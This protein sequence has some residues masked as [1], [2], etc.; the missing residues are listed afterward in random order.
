M[1]AHI[2]KGLFWELN[3]YDRSICLYTLKDEDHEGLPSL[4]R[5]YMEME[6]PTEWRFANEYLDGWSH[7]EKIV[8]SPWFK[9]HVTRWRKELDLKMRA[10]ALTAIREEAEGL[11]KNSFQANK[12]ILEK[13]WVVNSETKSKRGR[14]TKDDI[15]KEAVRLAEE[16]TAYDEDAERILN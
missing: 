4:Y 6:D 13:G 3:E 15:K 1:G 10:K 9:D 16:S 11:G 5:L 14:P 8:G 7:W 12:Y 2:T